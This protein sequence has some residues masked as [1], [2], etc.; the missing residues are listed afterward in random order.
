M[1][2]HLKDKSSVVYRSKIKVS[3]TLG[4]SRGLATHREQMNI[5]KWITIQSQWCCVRLAVV[6]GD[7]SSMRR[8][9][10][11]LCPMVNVRI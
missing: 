4:L 7:G 11:H 5:S 3:L 8:A 1:A 10:F 9:V 2:T 6:P